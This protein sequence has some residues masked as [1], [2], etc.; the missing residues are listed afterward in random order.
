MSRLERIRPAL[1][2]VAEHFEALLGVA[3]AVAIFVV[4][5]SAMS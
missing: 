4:G 1:A 5:F 2:H 3:L